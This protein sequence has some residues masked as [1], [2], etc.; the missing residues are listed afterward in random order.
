MIK[1]INRRYTKNRK[2]PVKDIYDLQP[3]GKVADKKPF[4]K[5]HLLFIPLTVINVLTVFF[6]FP[7]SLGRIVESVRDLGLSIAYYFCEMFGFENAIV[8]TVTEV[9]R[10]PF[11]SWLDKFQI[12][13]S[14]A[15]LPFEWG[16]FVIKWK[17]YWSLFFSWDNLKNYLFDLINFLYNVSLIAM[18]VFPFIL[19]IKVLLNMEMKRE[20]NDYCRQSKA[21][22]LFKKAEVRFLKPLKRGVIHI[23]DFA[24]RN[25]FYLKIWL[26]TWL[27]NFNIISVLIE[28]VAFYFYFI[29]SFDMIHFYRQIYKLFIDLSVMLKFVPA[30]VWILAGYVLLCVIRKKVGYQRLNHM[31]RKNEG[32]I[33]SQPIVVLV[34]G[35]MRTG[36][37]T[38]VTDMGLSLTTMFRRQA[39][40][41]LIEVFLKYPNFP[42][43]VL[44]RQILKAMENHSLYNLA[45][46]KHFTDSKRSVYEKVSC[47]KNMFGYDFKR[48]GV[49]YDDSLSVTNIW[50]DIGDYVKAYFIYVIECS[51][52]ITNYGVREDCI[53]NSLGNFPLWNDDFFKKKS[54]ELP[55]ISRY[56]HIVDYDCLRLG[57]KVVEDNVMK[58][59]FDF[60]VVLLM[61]IGKER[62]NNLELK[63]VKKVCYSANQKNDLFDAELKMMGHAANVRNKCFVRF[64]CDEQRPESWGANARELASIVRIEERGEQCIAMPFYEVRDLL[65]AFLSDR[66][67]SFYLE[68]RFARGDISLLF[69]LYSNFFAAIYKTHLRNYNT[70]GYSPVKV[71]TE[72]GTL[73]GVRNEHEYYYLNKKV[74]SSRFATDGFSGFYYNKTIK[75]GYGIGD[76]P[77]YADIHAT[78]AELEKQN[79]YFVR[80]LTAISGDE[81][82]GTDERF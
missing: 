50:G 39:M 78:E 15:L 60:G 52:L 66:F 10:F 27:L 31:E 34:V 82:N 61:E 69:Y 3:R 62:G 18:T 70:F 42:W 11:W 73:D 26:F 9:Q 59:S 51:L 40:E 56:S 30:P 7:Y 25:N 77:C 38:C 19:M 16:E 80:D 63:E 23:V 64:V 12:V 6:V 17:A 58:D 72:K 65:Y 48:Y 71:Q 54:A 37:T 4:E 76:M 55:Q 81:E 2:K 33:N 43:I 57:M 22:L 53:L 5:L 68:Y 67:K 14:E 47:P 24:K 29:F 44:E 45:T 13:K 20:N 79:S 46:C 75:S 41:I 36:K 8:P 28:A 21:L 74:Y 49:I 35:G 32:F 1:F